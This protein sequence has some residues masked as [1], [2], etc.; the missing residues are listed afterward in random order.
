MKKILS[1]IILL[2]CMNFANAADAD[3][4]V[5]MASDSVKLALA[6][7]GVEGKL[8]ISING[9]ERGFGLKHPEED[10][11]VFIS[12]LSI[13]EKTK[14]WRGVISFVTKDN[15]S[16]RFNAAGSFDKVISIPVLSRSMPRDSVLKEEDLVFVEVPDSQVKYDTV[17]DS[18]KLIGQAL[19]RTIGENTPIK[20]KD[21]QKAQI[22]ARNKAVNIVYNT[23]SLSLK[24]LGIAMESGG[25]GDIIKVKN[26][27][28]GKIVQAIIQDDQNV[29]AIAHSSGV[30]QNSNNKTAELEGRRYAR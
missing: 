1:V 26:S 11:E 19:K 17:A 13:N 12:D 20:E 5:E 29:S 18:E 28:S 25:E 24:T 4:S 10:Y 21:L 23:P 3:K 15:K 22:L 2:S 14:F 16:E 6:E 27:S 7:K 30:A 9:A 8:R